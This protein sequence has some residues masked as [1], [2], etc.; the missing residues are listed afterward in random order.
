MAKDIEK[1]SKA[2]RLLHQIHT[3]AFIVLFLT[4]M[5][6][7]FPAFA[8]IVQGGWTKYLH[9][10]AACV[11]VAAPLLFAIIDWEGAKKSLKEAFNWGSRDVEWLKAAPRYYFLGD[12]RAMPPQDHMN[13]GQ[14]LW[15]TIVVIFGGLFILTGIFMWLLASFVPQGV[16]QW[17]LFF[18]DLSFIVTGV[19]LI[20]H[21]YL[22]VIH[23]FM[24]ESWNAIWRGTVSEEYAKSHHGRWYEEVAGKSK[25]SETTE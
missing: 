3:V 1:Y 16:Y 14:K 7:F 24:T 10:V 20:V 21:I 17:M 6:L 25:E 13:S 8:P 2:A 11:F 22:G 19:M 4:G 12:E 18:H 15:W 5:F 9:R 23:P